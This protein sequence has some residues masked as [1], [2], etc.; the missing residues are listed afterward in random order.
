MRQGLIVIISGPSGVGKDAVFA[1]LKALGYPAHYA[2]TATSRPPRGQEQDGVSYHFLST[3]EFKRRIQQG[4]LLE[5]AE[6]YG[7]YYGVPR[8]EV[9]VPVRKGKDVVVKV[10]VQGAMTL[11][12]AFPESLAVFIMPPSEEELAERL[13]KRATDSMDDVNHRLEI[14]ESEMGKKSVF[15]YIVVNHRDRLDETVLQVLGIINSRKAPQ[16]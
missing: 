9:E 11:K 16:K 10:D 2:I 4:R 3:E 15:D 13:K 12:T 8:E 6:V 14:A 7:N 1:R 5:W